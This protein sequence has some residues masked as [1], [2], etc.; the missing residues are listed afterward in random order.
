[1]PTVRQATEV[2]ISDLSDAANVM[3]TSD[4]YVFPANKSGA[5]TAGSCTTGAIVTIGA[6][7]VDC[8]VAAEDVVTPHSSVTVTVSKATGSLSPVVTIAVTSA[9]TQAVIDANGA[10]VDIP[11]TFSYQGETITFHKY[12]SLGLAKTG[13]DGAAAYNYFLSVSPDAI[14]RNEDG[15]YSSL[16]VTMTG[17]RSQ[18]TGTPSQQNLFYWVHKTTDGSTWTEVQKY[19]TGA[20]TQTKTLTAS[21]LS[22]VVALRVTLHTASP[23]A[24]NQVDSQTIA[25]VDAGATGPQGE[26]AYTV[27]LTN[28]SHTFPATADGKAIAGTAVCNVVAYKGATQVPA[29]IGT[30]SGLVTG[31]TA[32]ITSNGT[33]S[34]KF[35]ATATTSLAT[36]SGVLTVPVTVDGKTFTKQFSWSLSPTGETGPQGPQGE[37]GLSMSITSDNGT[38]LR[39]NSGNTTLTAHVWQD[40]AEVTG[41]DL[42]ALGTLKWYKDGT[43]LTGKDGATLTVAATDVAGKSV[44]T[45][46]LE[47]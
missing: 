4:A 20:K 39:N 30:I 28:E 10:L 1:M 29:T 19:T 42:S 12:F 16:S 34:A 26:P 46:K 24:A 31:L 8:N 32:P 11:V 25:I 36:R 7:Q 41:A 43:Y 45:C 47:G 23:A 38:T 27:L 18:G 37:G 21:D 6:T 2:T 44:Y 35:T 9:F 40:G 15:S 17:T 33:T 14:V 22:G 13:A 5:A 3:L